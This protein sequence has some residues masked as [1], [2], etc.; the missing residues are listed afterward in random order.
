MGEKSPRKFILRGIWAGG[1]W[2]GGIWAGAGYSP[3]L[4]ERP[5]RAADTLLYASNII[6][7]EK[8]C[9]DKPD[10]LVK[11]HKICKQTCKVCP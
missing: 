5:D 8:K 3:G 6:D 2:A 4:Q 11:N 1:I 9:T 10:F 7:N